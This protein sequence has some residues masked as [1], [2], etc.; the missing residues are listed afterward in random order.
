MIKY[1][2]LEMG[3]HWNDLIV[4]C[5]H[6]EPQLNWP[7]RIVKQV[8]PAQAECLLTMQFNKMMCYGCAEKL[9]TKPWPTW[10][11]AQF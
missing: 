1:L 8:S 7:H 9:C 3:G 6:L 2:V 4:A 10:Y 5:S 11:G